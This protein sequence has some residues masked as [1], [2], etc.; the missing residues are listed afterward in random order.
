[1]LK[2]PPTSL[3]KAVHRLER[4]G[5]ITSYCEGKTRIYQLNQN[6]P[7]IKELEQLLKRAY[8]L[9]PN[10]EKKE[11]YAITEDTSASGNRKNHTQ[12]LLRFWEKLKGITQLTFQ[13]RTKEKTGWSGKGQGK[14]ITTKLG[15]NGLL[16]TEKGI[17]QDKQATEMHFSNTFRWTL[18]RVARMI[19]LEHLRRGPDYPVFLFNLAPVGT[20]ALASIDAHLCGEDIYCGQVD[21]D[22]YSIYLRWRVIGPRKNEEIDYSYS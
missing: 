6:Y 1:L 12:V 9:L 20:H 10:H 15:D 3:Q 14:V 2:I 11:Y 17:W 5:L 21:F 13:A 7:L 8:I 16:F 22:R 18:D 19:S 4:E